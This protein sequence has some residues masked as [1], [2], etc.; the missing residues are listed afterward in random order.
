MLGPTA[1]T[2][3]VGSLP[4]L[5]C[6]R[7]EQQPSRRRRPCPSS[8]HEP[9]RLRRCADRREESGHNPRFCTV[10]AMRI[11]CDGDVG[12]R[13]AVVR[14]RGRIPR[15]HRPPRTHPAPCT[16]R[17]RTSDGVI[18][19]ERARARSSH[20]RCSSSRHALEHEFA[21]AEAMR[22]R[23]PA[24]GAHR[25]AAPHGSCTH[26]KSPL[27]LG[28]AMSTNIIGI[29][30][31]ATEIDRI[32]AAIARYGDRFLAPRFHGG[33]DCVRHAPPQPGASFRR[34]VRGEG[35]GDEGARHRSLAGRAVARYRSRASR[36]PAATAVSW[37]RGEAI[38]HAERKQLAC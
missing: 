33:R 24:S 2:R 35:G 18:D 21:R 1:A 29:G 22:A 23:S 27:G 14:K 36:R 28:N 4:N 5:R 25:R 26:S 9:R 30:M 6:E 3:S 13:P 10:S 31:D 16:C 19:A 20:P 15:P 11:A 7:L 17:S 8:R 37:R 34:A 12:F 38:Q 32:D